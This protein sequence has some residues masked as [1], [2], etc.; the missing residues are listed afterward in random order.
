MAIVGIGELLWDL[1]PQGRRLGGAPSN[2]A[3]HCRCLGH[4]AAVVSRVGADADGAD[5]RASLH[6]LGLDD[7][8]VQTEADHP[9]G[10]VAVTVGP[11]G[12]PT[13]AIAPD[14]AWDFLAWDDRLGELLGR[15]EAVCFGTLAQRH[16]VAR[17]TIRRALAAAPRALIV[18][19]VNLRQHYS[20]RDVVEESLRASRWV[21]LNEDELIVL[22]EM[23]ALPGGESEALAALRQR[24]GAELVCLTCGARGCVVQTAREQVAVPGERVTVVDTVGAGDAFTAGLLALS[25]EGRPLAEAARFAT[26]LAGRVVA[27]AGATPHIERAEI[28]RPS[29]RS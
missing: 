27:S 20:S 9:T 6:A 2:F 3:F 8:H 5:L 21:K 10:S 24:Y 29:G 19:D 17:G 1:L 7:A 11:D 13:F 26:R 25:L 16:P 4:E 23:F 18:C 15:A 22:R 14:V 28:E 12:Q